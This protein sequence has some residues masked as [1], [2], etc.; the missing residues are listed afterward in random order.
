MVTDQNDFRAL[1]TRNNEDKFMDATYEKMQEKAAEIARFIEQHNFFR[2]FT[3]NDGDGITSVSILIEAFRKKGIGFHISFISKLNKGFF[4]SYKDSFDETTP[5]IFCDIG[6]SQW[7]A[8]KDIKNPIIIL[9]HHTFSK[10]PKTPYFLNPESYGVSGSYQMCA[11]GACY[12]VAKEMDPENS[13]LAGL[14]VV[15]IESDRQKIEAVNKNIV[16]DAQKYG[17]VEI[18]H[19][20]R[21][22]N[23]LLKDVFMAYTDP[24]I[25]VTG[26]PEK[27]DAYL[28][29]LGLEGKKTEDLTAEEMKI[30]CDAVESELTSCGCIEGIQAVI[31]DSFILKNHMIPNVHD[32]SCVINSCANYNEFGLAVSVCLNDPSSLDEAMNYFKKNQKTIIEDLKKTEPLVR[33]MENITYMHTTG[34]HTAGEIASAYI[35]YRM[36]EKPVICLN[37]N[38]EN[39]RISGRGT[40]ALVKRG[41][42]LAEA[43]RAAAEAAGGKG[44]GHAISSGA[45]VPIGKSTDF[46][47]DLNRIVGEQLHRKNG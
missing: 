47:T 32:F 17:I 34:L 29:K 46:L 6:S 20:L 39:I 21:I 8:L 1:P 25:D 36:P 41:L 37:E 13:K 3:H 30:L 24:Y 14:A 27:I 28:K 40:H 45:A 19:G 5:L 43:F 11:S 9:D 22:G 44:G 26:K 18:R 31:G 38:E 35:R 15:G 7:D 12:I 2:I 16:K 23:G 42:D 4:E 33:K 10:E